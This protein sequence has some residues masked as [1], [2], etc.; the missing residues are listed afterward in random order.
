VDQPQIGRMKGMKFGEIA[1]LNGA[2]EVV[3]LLNS[4]LPSVG[5]GK[6]STPRSRKQNRSIEKLRQ[7]LV[8]AGDRAA[9]A[10]CLQGNVAEARGALANCAWTRRAKIAVS[11]QHGE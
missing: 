11:R 1:R 9:G 10:R 5:F 3:Q 6:F 7:L 8:S 2:R 4:M